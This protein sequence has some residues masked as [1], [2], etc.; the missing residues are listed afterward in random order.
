MDEG[1]RSASVVVTNAHG[2]HA[3]PADLFVKLA[4]QF[5]AKVEVLKDGERVDGKSIIDVLTLGA[6]AGT[7]LVIE[8]QGADAQ[9]ALEALTE[10]V[11]NNFGESETETPTD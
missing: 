11:R 7:E 5:A 8:A 4:R 9:A 3:R 6:A 2:V 10:L 1:P